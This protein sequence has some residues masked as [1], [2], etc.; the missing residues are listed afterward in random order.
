[1]A[2][3]CIRPL[4][5]AEGKLEERFLREVQLFRR[6]AHPNVCR[7]YDV[8]GELF[9]MERLAGETLAERLARGKRYTAEEALPIMRQLCDGLGAAHQA[10]VLHRDLKPGNVFLDG[11]RVVI[12]DFGLAAGTALD[13]AL[14]SAGAVIGTLA[15][16]APGQL[17]NGHCTPA[18]DIY[19]LGV[20]LHEM[21][22]GEKPHPAKSPFRLAAQK[23]RESHQTPDTAVPGLPEVWQEVLSRCLKADPAARFQSAGEVKALLARG[24]PSRSYVAARWRKRLMIPALALLTLA[25]GAL[26]LF[27]RNMGRRPQPAAAAFYQ[28]AQAALSETAPVRAVGLLEKAVAAEPAFVHARAQLTA[29]YAEIDQLDQA[30]DTLLQA[31]TNRRWL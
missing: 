10:G 1:M 19:S 4:A 12:I 13:E 14:P 21:V 9:A 31:D 24:K 6:I 29:A 5:G 7:V 26:G 17:E 3:K 22:T 20:V 18:S 30:R 27:W 15:Y 16:V 8:V 23:A 11:E 28:Q 25:V 2:L